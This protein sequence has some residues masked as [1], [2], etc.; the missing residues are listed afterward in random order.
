M[1]SSC[2]D[3]RRTECGGP[4]APRCI[5]DENRDPCRSKNQFA[6]KRNISNIVLIANSTTSF[7]SGMLQNK[8]VY[9]SRNGL[10]NHKGIVA[11]CVALAPRGYYV[12][13]FLPE[14]G[15]E[16]TTSARLPETFKTPLFQLSYS[17]RSD[18]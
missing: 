4:Q 7:A 3:N 18:F 17:G 2:Q 16:P 10:E 9:R 13:F 11:R 8:N 12:I 1:S 14:V 15:I 6:K 5:W